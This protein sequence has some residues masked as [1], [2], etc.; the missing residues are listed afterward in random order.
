MSD[1]KDIN[2]AAQLR[3][4]LLWIDPEVQANKTYG[5][6][7][8]KLSEALSLLDAL[9]AE[10]NET[11]NDAESARKDRR[12]AWDDANK[13][14]AERDALTARIAELEA[15]MDK[16]IKAQPTWA[17]VSYQ[18]T[19]DLSDAQHIARAALTDRG[20]SGV[21]GFESEPAEWNPGY[22]VKKPTPSGAE[23]T[24]R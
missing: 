18:G 5:E 13:A 3:E 10:L 15:A 16:I 1:T 23:E 24:T 6:I 8:D 9:E 19:F 7:Q 20:A 22:S 12:I 17:G 2:H 11:R 4:A 14:E 21:D